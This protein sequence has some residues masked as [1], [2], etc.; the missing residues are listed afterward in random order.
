MYVFHSDTVVFFRQL[1]IIAPVSFDK[2]GLF[3]RRILDAIT[4]MTMILHRKMLSF[5]VFYSEMYEF[6]IFDFFYGIEKEP[7]DF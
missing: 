4:M 1:F 3:R 7:F 5:T 6:A 2:H